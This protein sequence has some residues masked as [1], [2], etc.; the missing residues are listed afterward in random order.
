MWHTPKAPTTFAKRRSSRRLVYNI[1][2]VAWE[3]HC[4]T[5]NC[6]IWA[7]LTKQ[8]TNI[9][10]HTKAEGAKHPRAKLVYNIQAFSLTFASRRWWGPSACAT[11]VY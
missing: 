5:I 1:S 10:Q 8:L 4:G 9:S 6:L 11:F 7:F 3:F 2:D